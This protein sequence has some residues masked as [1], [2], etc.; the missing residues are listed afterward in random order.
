MK[1]DTQLELK[2]K[3]HKDSYLG[4][5]PLIVVFILAIIIFSIKPIPHV[6]VIL[7]MFSVFLFS[8]LCVVYCEVKDFMRLHLEKF[9]NEIEN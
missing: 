6:G 9:I 5:L 4:M 1:K 2:I 7:V 3:E 8:I